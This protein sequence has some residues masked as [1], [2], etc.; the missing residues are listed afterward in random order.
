MANSLMALFDRLD[1]R[2]IVVVLVTFAL[3]M[4]WHKRRTIAEALPNIRGDFLTRHVE[5]VKRKYTY[6]G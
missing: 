3:V 6:M 1:P 5:T 4:L 2:L